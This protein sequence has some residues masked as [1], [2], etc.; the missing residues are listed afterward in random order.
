MPRQK[1]KR[2]TTYH[3]HPNT[4]SALDIH[5]MMSYQLFQALCAI[6]LVRSHRMLKL[7]MI[8]DEDN[9]DSL[10]LLYCHHLSLVHNN[11]VLFLLDSMFM[12]IEPEDDIPCLLQ[13]NRNHTLDLLDNGWCYHHTRFSVVQLHELYQRLNLPVSLTISTKGH[14]ASSEE[15][16]IITLTKLATGSSNT[17]LME[18]SPESSKLPS[19][20]LTI[21]LMEFYTAIAL[22]V[23]F[24]CFLG[25]LRSLKRS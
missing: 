2:A 1:S 4:L 13:A 15:A 19:N 9:D 10:L 16:F 20:Y 14:K 24:I 18:V 23:G 12:N 25:L 21:R 11:N 5:T 17:S 22:S 6:S 8:L 7:S 3:Q